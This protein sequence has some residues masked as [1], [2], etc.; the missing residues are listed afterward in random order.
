VEAGVAG[1]LG[2]AA[3]QDLH[4]LLARLLPAPGDPASV[5]H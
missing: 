3:K 5:R 4:A 1:L 2:P